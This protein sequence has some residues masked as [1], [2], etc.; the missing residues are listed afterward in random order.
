MFALIDQMYSEDI[1]QKDF[2]EREDIKYH[3]LQ[4]WLNHYRREKK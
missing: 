2:C 3:T 4:Y 1:N